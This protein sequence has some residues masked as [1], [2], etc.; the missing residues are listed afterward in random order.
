MLSSIH[1]RSED[2]DGWELR[3]WGRGGAREVCRLVKEITP[4]STTEQYRETA[5]LWTHLVASVL[6]NRSILTMYGEVDHVTCSIL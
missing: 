1:S 6:I 2:M 5:L 4:Y 3:G